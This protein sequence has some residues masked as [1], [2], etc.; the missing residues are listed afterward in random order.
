M[1]CA[2]KRCI[3]N[4]CTIRPMTDFHELLP[5]RTI[6]QFNNNNNN[7]NKAFDHQ[8]ARMFVVPNLFSKLV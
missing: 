6:E 5:F 4:S 8:N 2:D 1:S 3:F 7:T